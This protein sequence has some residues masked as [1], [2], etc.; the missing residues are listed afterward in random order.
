[1]YKSIIK[2]G[3]FC[4]SH[5]EIAGLANLA[6]A[7]GVIN[8][9]NDSDFEAFE[10]RGV[11]NAPA[12]LTGGLFVQLSLQSGE[13]FSNVALDAKTFSTME[14]TANACVSNYP[15]R[16]PVDT[17]IPAN[18]VINVQ[19]NN[20]TGQTLDFQLQIWGYKVEKAS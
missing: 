1:M 10:I 18:S 5:T 17:R 6:Q 14:G 8:I 3:M 7:T 4:Y 9:S 20:Q 11:I 13:L 16:L 15:I 2:P 12:V 19:V